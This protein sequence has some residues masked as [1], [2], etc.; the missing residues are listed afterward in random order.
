MLKTKSS[1][2]KMNLVVT[3]EDHDP[4]G[5]LAEVEDRCRDK[6]EAVKK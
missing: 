5:Q 4:I 6:I 1:K 2:E 3:I